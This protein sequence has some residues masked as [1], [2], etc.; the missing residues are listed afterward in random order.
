MRERR[1]SEMMDF[2]AGVKFPY[3]SIEMGISPWSK[4]PLWYVRRFGGGWYREASFLDPEH[5]SAKLITRSRRRKGAILFE[6][7]QA[8]GE[9]EE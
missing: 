8:I 4:T 3:Q 6:R 1:K 2:W 7:K 9:G 5:L